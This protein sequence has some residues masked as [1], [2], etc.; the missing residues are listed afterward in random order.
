MS[1]LDAKPKLTVSPGATDAGAGDQVQLLSGRRVLLGESSE[2]RRLLPN[3]GRRMVGAWCFLDSYGPDDIEA[4]AGMRVGP[5]PHCGLQTVS[6]LLDGEVLHRDSLGS[7]QVLRPGQLGLMTAGR[8][9]SHAEESPPGHPPILHGAQLWVALPDEARFAP[10]SFEFHPSLP[11]LEDG[12]LGA[13]VLIGELGGA[14]SP[15]SAFSPLLGADV[16][17][18]AEARVELPLEADF[19]HAVLPMSGT[20][21]VDGLAVSPGVLLYLG[22]GRTRLSL[23]ADESCRL[24]LLGGTPFEQRIVMWWNFV[25]RSGEEIAAVREEWMGGGAFG[26][27]HGYDGAPIPAPELPPGTLKARGRS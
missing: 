25:A 1:N 8:G 27:V 13:R 3:L 22:P 14:R 6:W 26:E 5:H 10:P 17:L 4:T 2:V 9:I 21:G 23:R 12:A 7:E 18:S 24:L 19:E 16:S 11:V 15:A 20:V